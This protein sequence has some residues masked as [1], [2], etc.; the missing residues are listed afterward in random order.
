M[1][2]QFGSISHGTLRTEDLLESFAD[3]LRN[4][5]RQNLVEIADLKTS[6]AQ[7]MQWFEAQSKRDQLIGSARTIDPDS[8]D[9]A[10]LV[11]EL[12][13]ALNEFAPSFGYFGT[14]PGDGSDF[15]Y[16]L[17]EDWQQMMRDDDVT[18]VDAGDEIPEDASQVCF[19]TDHG[20]AT[21]G[22]VG[23]DGKFVEVW[24]VV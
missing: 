10:E 11:N 18:F 24:S 1:N 5:S 6:D 2:A 12:I 15:G 16:W 19:V 4:I 17:H 20:N 7:F 8:E 21:F 3:A 22:Y 9:A 23:Q 13:D 14:H